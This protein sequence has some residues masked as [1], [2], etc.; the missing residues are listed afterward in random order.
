MSNENTIM[1]D[2]VVAAIGKNLGKAFSDDE[3]VRQLISHGAN[4]MEVL[5]LAVK[6]MECSC[7]GSEKCLKCR[8]RIT[9]ICWSGWA[10]AYMNRHEMLSGGGEGRDTDE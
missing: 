1:L 2:G 5:A 3:I 6:D 4:M 7:T 10:C 8:A 9:S